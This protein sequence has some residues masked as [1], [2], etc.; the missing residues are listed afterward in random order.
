MDSDKKCC[1][2]CVH[3]EW[4][5][6]KCTKYQCEVDPRSICTLYQSRNTQYTYDSKTEEKKN[7]N[8]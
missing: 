8:H 4:Y 5:Y 3:Y 6:D 2:T 1:D 7:E